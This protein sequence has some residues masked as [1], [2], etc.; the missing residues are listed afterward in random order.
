MGD[1]ETL[2]EDWAVWNEADDRCVL[3]Y[4]PDV[5]D[6]NAF[7]AAC[8]PTIYLTRGRRSRRP[9]RQ[10]AP[11]TANTW[12]VTLFLEPE[13]EREAETYDTRPEAVAGAVALAERFAAGE[14]DYRGL[15]QVP[16][17]AYLDE[18]D[19]LTGGG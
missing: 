1:F 10:R 5:F 18:L 6:T 3:V 15:Y 7:D 14:V 13:V 16:R 4:R 11:G 8:L 12:Y 9:G 19:A 2:P 17:E